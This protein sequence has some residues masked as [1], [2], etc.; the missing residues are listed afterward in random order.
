[1]NN[2]IDTYKFTP[3]ASTEDQITNLLHNYGLD[4][5]QKITP[6]ADDRIDIKDVID[7]LP[8]ELTTGI[9][10]AHKELSDYY[11]AIPVK[12]RARGV[13]VQTEHLLNVL[14]DR[15]EFFE[16]LTRGLVR[17]CK[18][19]QCPHYSACPYVGVIDSV[20]ESEQIQCAVERDIVKNAVSSFIE[21]DQSGK[22]RIDPRRPEMMLLFSQL[23]QLMVKQSR[24]TMQLQMDDVL[25]DYYEV[26]K[27][28]DHDTFQS[29]N[30]IEH[31]MMASWEKTHTSIQKLMQNMGI[32]PEFQIKQ[33]MW[34][35]ESSKQDAQ[36]RAL[37][38]AAQYRIDDLSGLLQSLPEGDPMR[39]M[40][41]EAIDA[42][43]RPALT[44]NQ[45]T[46]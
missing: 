20:T 32:T 11:H 14:M 4:K 8:P 42:A 31:P 26:L 28:G 27:D 43:K 40:I 45:D 33:G 18:G 15:L 16:G 36:A 1:M 19:Q 37:E 30:L 44:H 34:V 41:Q 13:K 7:M 35:D 25:V 12:R 46:E 17:T 39:A 3:G 10:P 5:S 38:L 21:P 22:P 29:K 2:P 6:D 23:I 24:I 9:N